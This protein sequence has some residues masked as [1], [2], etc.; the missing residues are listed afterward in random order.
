MFSVRFWGVRGSMPCPGLNTNIFGGNTTCLEIRAD[1]KIILVDCGTGI[2]D[3]GRNLLNDP[4]RANLNIEIFLSH[5]H[6]DHIL[7]LPLFAPIFL[8]TTKIHIRG[9][10]FPNGESLKSIF[11]MLTSY[12]FWPIR[13]NEFPAKFSFSQLWEQTVNLGDGIKVISKYTNHPVICLA[14]RIEYEGKSIVTAFDTEPYRNQFSRIVP[15]LPCDENA[16]AA[17]EKAAEMENEKMWNFM[18]GTDVLIYDSSYTEDE[19]NASKLN[20]GHTSYESAIAT[21]LKVN[22]KK[23]VLTHHEPTRTDDQLQEIEYKYRAL[24]PNFDTLEITLAKEGLVLEL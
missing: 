23:L 14:Y 3:A 5:T 15:L 17:G 13:L 24:Y 22:A 21:A 12:K 7:G 6:W 11:S 20:W 9:P 10:H 8:P 16:E 1:D 4:Q 18:K 19:Y 2:K